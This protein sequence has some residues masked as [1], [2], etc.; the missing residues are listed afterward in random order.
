MVSS[1]MFIVH[2]QWSSSCLPWRMSISER[3][4]PIAPAASAIETSVFLRVF[5]TTQF[6]SLKIV[7]QYNMARICSDC[8]AS[9]DGSFL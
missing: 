5:S 8:M 2:W 4:I 9:S 1:I 6:T 7:M 3:G